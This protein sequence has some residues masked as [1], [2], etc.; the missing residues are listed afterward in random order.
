M[1]KLVKRE[2]WKSWLAKRT[3]ALCF[4]FY[5]LFSQ[6]NRFERIVTAKEKLT[7]EGLLKVRAFVQNLRA[8]VGARSCFWCFSTEDTR[9]G[10]FQSDLLL[11]R[12]YTDTWVKSAR[13][14]W[15]IEQ[16]PWKPRKPYLWSVSVTLRSRYENK[17]KWIQTFSILNKIRWWDT[18]K[19]FFL[20]RGRV[21]FLQRRCSVCY[22]FGVTGSHDMFF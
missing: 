4:L 3:L 13:P 6:V 1:G 19:F 2:Q 17:T 15:T 9:G 18:P 14:I 8:D 7:S 21:L 20:Q 11:P 22:G 12:F 16:F 10:F 5:W